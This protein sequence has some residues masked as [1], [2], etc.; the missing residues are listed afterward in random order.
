M[1]KKSSYSRLQQGEVIT[2]ATPVANEKTNRIG[3]EIIQRYARKN[4]FEVMPDQVVF[5]AKDFYLI[6]HIKKGADAAWLYFYNFEGIEAEHEGMPMVFMDAETAGFANFCGL[7][8]FVTRQFYA[9]NKER[10]NQFTEAIRQAI[11]YIQ[12]NPQEVSSIYYQFSME[13]P[14]EL[15]DDILLATIN[16][17]NPNFTSSYADELPILHFFREIGITDLEDEKFK[18]AFI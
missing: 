4:G 15:M 3:L 10:V 1:M 6:D 18:T 9:D 14:S 13:E 7:D 2:V 5:D 16:C 11:R 12:A 17:F 8:I